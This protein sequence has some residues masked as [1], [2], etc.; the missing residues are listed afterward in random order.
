MAESSQPLLSPDQQG[1]DED[2][3]RE[4]VR[5]HDADM[6]VRFSCR[7][8]IHHSCAWPGRSFVLSAAPPFRLH[9]GMVPSP[10]FI[11]VHLHTGCPCEL[12]TN[13]LMS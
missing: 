11:G 2:G 7:G 8:I 1:G 12:T 3:R 9:W 13:A 5:I 4:Q 10:C 6:R